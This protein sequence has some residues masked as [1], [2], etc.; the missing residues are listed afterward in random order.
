MEKAELTFERIVIPIK[1]FCVYTTLLYLFY[2]QAIQLSRNSRQLSAGLRTKMNF[3]D[4]LMG[5]G[6]RSK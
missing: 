2:Y 4:A 3:E 6:D 5:E 1:D